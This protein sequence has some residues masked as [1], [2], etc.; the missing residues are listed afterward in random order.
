MKKFLSII[1]LLAVVFSFASCGTS[2]SNDTSG[3]NIDYKDA[4]SFEVNS[5]SSIVALRI[6]IITPYLTIPPE[7]CSS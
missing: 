1:I 3:N 4:K 7:Q 6:F 2:T 5:L